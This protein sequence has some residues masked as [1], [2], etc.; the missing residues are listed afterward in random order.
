[1]NSR[2]RVEAALAHEQPDYV[3]LDLGASPVTGMHVSSVY[4]LRQALKLDPPGTPVK[5]I[6]AYQMLGEIEP[7]PF[8]HLGDRLDQM[9]DRI[10]GQKLSAGLGE[11]DAIGAAIAAHQ[12]R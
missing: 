9:M 2:R 11:V 1:M 7:P 10:V 5:V 4:S 3:P 8:R 12:P 6:E